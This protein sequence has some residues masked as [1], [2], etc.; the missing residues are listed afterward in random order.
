[1]LEY[2]QRAVKYQGDI[3]VAI[4]GA[5]NQCAS[6]LQITEPLPVLLDFEA[7]PPPTRPPAEDEHQEEDDE[8]DQEEGQGEG[9][10]NEAG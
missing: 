6:R 10:P 1:M 3:A 7:P 4:M 8:E 9:G 5:L 2:Q